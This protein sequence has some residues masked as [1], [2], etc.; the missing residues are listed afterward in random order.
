MSGGWNEKGW[1]RI[2]RRPLW[3]EGNGVT[4][5]E[6]LRDC[7]ERVVPLS[8]YPDIYITIEKITEILS[9]FR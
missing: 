6:G 2:S 4:L 7:G 9:Q 1:D 3:L 5:A 8:K